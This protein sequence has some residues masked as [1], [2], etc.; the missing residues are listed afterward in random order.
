MEVWSYSDLRLRSGSAFAA[1]VT[2]SLFHL[3]PLTCSWNVNELPQ[4]DGNRS[5]WNIFSLAAPHRQAAK[6]NLQKTSAAT[7]LTAAHMLGHTHTH[8]ETFLDITYNPELT[9]TPD[10]NHPR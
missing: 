5:C 2:F 3:Y 8:T 1:R 7:T 6:E 9:L 4:M 10:P